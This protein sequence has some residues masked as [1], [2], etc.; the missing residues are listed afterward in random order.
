MVTMGMETASTRGASLR[1]SKV[2]QVTRDQ[3]MTTQYQGTNLR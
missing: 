3:P 1:R 2:I